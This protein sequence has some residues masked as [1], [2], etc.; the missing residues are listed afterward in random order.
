VSYLSKQEH[1][2]SMTCSP[3]TLS[4]AGIAACFYL[5]QMRQS[6]SFKTAMTFKYEGTV[7]GRLFTGNG[8]SMAIKRTHRIVHVFPIKVGSRSTSAAEICPQERRR[9]RLMA[10]G[11]L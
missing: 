10:A 6:C 3:W 4:R 11:P 1:R 8:L 9:D 5:Y 7:G 2:D